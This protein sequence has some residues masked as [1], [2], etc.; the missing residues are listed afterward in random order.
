MPWFYVDDGFSSSKPVMSLPDDKVRAPMHIAACGLWVLAGSWSAKE[1]LDGYVPVSKLKQLGATPSMVR[2][3]I[4]PG[5]MDAA[6]WELADPKNDEMSNECLTDLSQKSYD[7]RDKSL[8]H[9]AQSWADLGAIRFKNWSKWQKTKE[10]L[11]R[12]RLAQLERKRGQRSRG[13]NGATWGNRN[14]SNRDNGVDNQGDSTNGQQTGDSGNP[15]RTPAG[16]P[17]AARAFTNPTHT[18]NT[19]VETFGGGGG[20]SNAEASGRGTKPVNGHT[21]PSPKP[22]P[23][24]KNSL[25]EK[26]TPSRYCDNHPEGTKDPCSVCQSRRRAYEQWAVDQME[27]NEREAQAEAVE[28]IRSQQ[29]VLQKRLLEEKR[30]DACTD[31]DGIGY[32]QNDEKCTHPNVKDIQ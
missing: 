25:K 19:L 24:P 29:S 9:P 5:P 16:D 12:D 8:R 13:N 3:L 15:S 17:A 23:P 10:Q 27:Q 21:V 2:A 6:L 31:C 28:R 30:L 32:N 18:L 26:Q 22:P 20:L 7:I 14:L 4:T 1:E 11:E